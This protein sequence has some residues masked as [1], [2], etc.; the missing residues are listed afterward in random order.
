MLLFGGAC[1]TTALTPIPAGWSD[2][3]K[4]SI[5]AAGFA[6]DGSV[7]VSDLYARKPDAGKVA[8]VLGTDAGAAVAVRGRAVTKPFTAIDSLDWS[9]AREEVVFSA[10][11]DGD[12]DI[13]LVAA[14]G[15]DI[16]WL[17][18]DPSDELAV[19]WAP[20]GNKVSYVIKAP[21]GDVVRTLHIPTS[22]QYSIDFPWAE[23]SDV[24]WDAAAERMAVVLSSPDASSRVEVMRYDGSGRRVEV[25]AATT[26]R[27]T[28]DPYEQGLLLRPADIAYDERLPLV[29]W[30]TATPFAWSEARAE[31]VS[32]SRAALLLVGQV[33]D[34]AIVKLAAEPW[35]DAAALFVVRREAGPSLS[36]PVRNV[37]VPGG[38]VPEGFYRREDATVS[39]PPAVVQ[40]FAA[41]FIAGEL[42]KRTSPPNG[43]SR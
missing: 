10:E 36:R 23:V 26:A 5:R 8:S 2:A 35:A 41:A 6:A 34:P 18:D 12:F 21:G 39:V 19:E 29:V 43:S 30:E 17:P 11:R 4:P 33:T 38:E 27:I 7:V 40:S 1:A 16:V 22:F 14:E 42:K 37:I 15:G 20:R 3:P 28:V 25:P 31:L 32:K 24:S 9:E 13:G